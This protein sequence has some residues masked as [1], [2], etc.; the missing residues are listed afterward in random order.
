MKKILFITMFFLCGSLFAQTS[1][2]KYN[3]VEGRNS[4]QVKGDSSAV[5]VYWVNPDRVV[6]STTYIDTVKKVVS[7]RT[8]TLLIGGV[9]AKITIKGM[10]ATDSLEWAVGK[11]APV[12]FR[13][14]FGVT[15][16]ST[17]RLSKYDFAKVF[18]R[19][20]GATNAI[21]TYQVVVE[22]F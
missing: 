5:M 7:I 2:T 9:D 8:D 12:T 22:A 3:K 17:E 16:E 11:T 10:A 14:L 15:P 19:A 21:R 1:W 18:V 20:Y 13:R 4:Q 6:S